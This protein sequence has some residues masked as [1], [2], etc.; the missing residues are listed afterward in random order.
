MLV[1]SVRFIVLNVAITAAII[2]IG[3]AISY[4]FG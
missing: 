3:H 1:K 2:A 4:V